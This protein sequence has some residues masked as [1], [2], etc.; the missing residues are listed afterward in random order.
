MGREAE[1]SGIIDLVSN[2]AIVYD[3]ETLGA[4]YHTEDIPADMQEVVADARTFM[5]EAIAESDEELLEKYVGG[6]E[7]SEEE[8]IRGIR[9]GCLEMSLV[10]VLCGSAFKNKGVQP[11]LDMVLHLLPSPLDVPPVTGFDLEDREQEIVREAKNDEP[12]AALAFK[13][14]ADPH[15]TLSFIRVYSGRA[16]AGSMVLNARTGKRE[17]MGRLVKMHADKR[18][19]ITAIEAGDIAAVIGMKNSRTGDTLCDEK[20]PV[21]LE[22]IEFP[23]PVISVA[24]EPK[25]KADQEKLGGA[26]QKIATEDPSFRITS[27][28]ETGQTIIAG[29][30]EL[31][32][33]II[34]DRL[35]RE[36]KVEANVG[37]ASGSVP[38]DD[39]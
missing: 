35:T 33:E 2:K 16:D 13:I 19:E 1:F 17:R 4:S 28:E 27:D 9:K 7:L 34:V 38:R 29:M 18:E 6:E 15:G 14:I 31:H 24:V 25:T 11:L 26:L 32:L 39:Y 37:K 20:S 36:Y 30:G 23:D 21:L 8:I 10:P 5:L 22:A 3:E 12:F